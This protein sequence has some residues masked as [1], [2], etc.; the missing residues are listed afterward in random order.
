MSPSQ[1]SKNICVSIMSENLQNISIWQIKKFRRSLYYNQLHHRR[2]EV[3]KIENMLELTSIPRYSI[4]I[5]A[6]NH[7][8]RTKHGN[9]FSRK[10]HLQYHGCDICQKSLCPWIILCPYKKT[11]N[12]I[13]SSQRIGDRNNK[14][15]LRYVWFIYP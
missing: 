3:Q 5:S 14:R 2:W 1:R 15:T 9:V 7:S 6:K 10:Y 8:I 4:T 11:W 13:I 12:K